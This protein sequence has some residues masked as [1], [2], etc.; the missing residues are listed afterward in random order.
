MNLPVKHG[1]TLPMKAE[2]GALA[3]RGAQPYLET[4][5]MPEV[6]YQRPVRIGLWVL[7]LGFGGFLGWAGFAPLDEGVPATAVVSV[8]SKR[9][10]IDHLNG[11]IVEKIL[12]REG[13]AVA[14]GEELIVLNE[15]QSKASLNAVLSQWRV[16]AATEARLAAERRGLK[17]I[18]FPQ[19]LIDAAKDPEIASILRGQE[20]LFRS[21]RT[22]LEGELRIIRESVRGLEL[23]LLSLEQVGAGRDKQVQLFQEQL[24]SYRNLNRGGFVSRNQLLELERQ[25]SEVQGKQSEDFANIAGINAR[26][27]EFRMRGAQREIEYRR[28]VEAQIAEVQREVATLGERLAGLRDTHS[29]LVIRAPVSGTVVD[30]AFHTVDG[31]VKPGERIMDIVPAGDELIVEA[32]VAPQYVDRVRAGL[33]AN[34]H[35]DAYMTRVE[36]P[37]V[38]GTVAVVSADVLTDPRS[39]TPYYS[40][41]VTVP[42]E[43]LEKLGELKLQPGMQATVMVKT[44]ERTLLVY[45]AR[46]LLRRFASALAES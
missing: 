1:S 38:R 6:D 13:Q 34:V 3:F 2:D 28:E 9:K 40:M 11:G 27:A 14:Q 19:A 32:Q 22:A 44:G 5:A 21:R 18:V 35:F 36:R 46:P 4:P 29:R 26:L 45:L 25:M 30:L 42:S 43:E 17:T 37:V 23:Q 15:A 39:G 7:L 10:R 8:D 20:E 33:T 41:R 12:V 31:V 16:A 24:T